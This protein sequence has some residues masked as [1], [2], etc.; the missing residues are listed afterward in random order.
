MFTEI[1]LRDGRS[2]NASA[3]LQIILALQILLGDAGVIVVG[4]GHEIEGEEHRPRSS[5][6]GSSERSGLMSISS[7]VRDALAD[8]VQ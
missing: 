7:Q 1:I 8:N 4:G 6:L 3:G 5:A 2:L